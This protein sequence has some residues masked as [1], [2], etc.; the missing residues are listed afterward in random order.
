MGKY[1]DKDGV[2]QI[3]D[4]TKKEIKGRLEEDLSNYQKVVKYFNTKE[5]YDESSLTDQDI[6]FIKE[7]KSIIFN[8]EIYGKPVWKVFDE[9]VSPY[10]D[11]V[12][13]NKSTLEKVVTKE[14][15]KYNPSEWTP[16][17]I[18][19]IPAS[20]DVYETGE[21]GVLSLT[22]MDYNNPDTGWTGTFEEINSDSSV[23][24]VA[25][26]GGMTIS[27]VASTTSNV[28]CPYYGTMDSVPPI[29]LQSTLTS[30]SSKC[31]IPSDKWT[32]Y[33]CT[34]DINANWYPYED[35]TRY[36]CPSP[37]VSNGGKNPDY[38]INIGNYAANSLVKFNGKELTSLIIDVA[39]AQSNWKTAASITNNS[40]RNYIPA[41][42][43]T[44]RF[45]TIGTEQGDWYLPASG[46]LGY[47]AARFKAID[48]TAN[49]INSVFGNV[50]LGIIYNDNLT[51]SEQCNNGQ[52]VRM[53][54]LNS[55]LGTTGY[56]SPIICRA[57]TRLTI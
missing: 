31:H 1:L 10:L 20:H 17:G 30:N 12:L 24:M 22:Y 26:N 43:C 28:K 34:Q 18:V 51:G 40:G 23:H 14:L 42:C 41:A 27:G 54:T 32:G 16:I 53:S 8:G 7:D 35:N 15:E 38:H 25:G 9:Y 39:T 57:M 4:N 56:G 3:W 47:I 44:W 37:Y 13:V 33:K 6:A 45:H 5:E 48:E 2:K 29:K 21:C 49:F 19:V 36:Y 46:E 11:V 50:A 52:F 55:S